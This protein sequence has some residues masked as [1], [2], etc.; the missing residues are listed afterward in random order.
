MARKPRWEP[1]PYYTDDVGRRR[2]LSPGAMHQVMQ[3]WMDGES[4]R[5]IAEVFGISTSLVRTICYH[6]RKGEAR[7]RT[8]EE[9][10]HLRAIQ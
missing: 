2:K 10:R 9:V 4:A 8:E 7:I 5:V 1:N 6:T 3:M